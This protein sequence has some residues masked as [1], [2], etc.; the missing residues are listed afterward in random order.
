MSTL[1]ANKGILQVYPQDDLWNELA[2]EAWK[3]LPRAEASDF[4]QWNDNN[5]DR[6][7]A[8]IVPCIKKCDGEVPTKEEA[9]ELIDKVKT[10]G[11]PVAFLAKLSS[12][13]IPSFPE[14]KDP[15]VKEFFEGTFDP[16][17]LSV[18]TVLV[19][20]PAIEVK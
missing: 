19:I 6:H 15:T 10:L 5:G 11:E 12:L 2:P 20:Y 3:N 17:T 1:E 14:D 8:K 16:S 18:K 7:V 9:Q 4:F 13:H